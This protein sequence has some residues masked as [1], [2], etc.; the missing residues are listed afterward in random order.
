MGRQIITNLRIAPDHISCLKEDEVFV[1]GSNQ[2]GHHAG[3]A[4]KIANEKFGAQWGVGEGPT[5]ATYAIPSTFKS[6]DDILPHVY[7]FLQYAKENLQKKFLVTRVGCGTAGFYDNEMCALF[8]DALKLPNVFLPRK[9]VKLLL[10]DKM[11]FQQF[12]G[13]IPDDYCYMNAV[14]EE[15]L[16]KLSKR[17]RRQIVT[18]NKSDLPDIRIRY[19]KDEGEFGFVDFGDCFM[20]DSNHFYIFTDTQNGGELVSN[21]YKL[22]P[23]LKEENQRTE[24]LCRMV[25][26]GIGTHYVDSNGDEIFTGDV[27]HLLDRNWYVAL[28]TFGCNSENNIAQYAFVLDNHCLFPEDCHKMTRVGTVFFDLDIYRSI[29]VSSLAHSYNCPFSY[30]MSDEER[31][32]LAIHT[33]SFNQESRLVLPRLNKSRDEGEDNNDAERNQKTEKCIK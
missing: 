7:K 21:D 20:I 1:F 18:G 10:K 23:F 6:I 2:K 13:N 29:N 19:V 17:Y 24:K 15:D 5:G 9:W 12:L 22:K 28:G 27:L 11:S 33:P 16:I 8:K 32:M 26:A 14:T 31:V 4:A 3:G 30:R 25:F